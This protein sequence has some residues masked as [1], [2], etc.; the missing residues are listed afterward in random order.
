MFTTINA[1]EILLNDD[2]SLSVNLFLYVEKNMSEKIISYINNPSYKVWEIKDENGL[3]I[4]HKSC[5]LNNTSLSLSMV[6]ETKRRLGI[7]ANFTSFI[8]S[9]TDEGLTPLHYTAYKGN[10]EVSKFYTPEEFEDLQNLAKKIGIKHYQINPLV[11]SSYRA[12]EMV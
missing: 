5:Y 7:S 6:R 8:N 4:L 3:T 10:L 1:K 9:K 11:R 12:A 2:E